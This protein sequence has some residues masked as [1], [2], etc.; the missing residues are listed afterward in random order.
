MISRLL[1]DKGYNEFVTVAERIKKKYP[2]V[3]CEIAGTINE[4]TPSGVPK[5][6]VEEDDRAGRIKYLGHINDITKELMDSNTVVVLPSYYREGM[7]RSLMEACS[8]GRPIITTNLPGLKEMVADGENGYLVRPRDVDSL[9]D[10]IILFMNLT[11]E[12]RKRMGVR[13]RKIAE[14]RFDV[15]RVKDMYIQIITQIK[16]EYV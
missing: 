16:S 6:V 7:N 14:E 4:E 9:Y 2:D 8:C 3:T 10:A 12:E 5:N 1:Y 15:E 13:S 11:I